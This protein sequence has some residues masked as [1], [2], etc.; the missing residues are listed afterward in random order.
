MRHF[1]TRIGG[2]RRATP[3]GTTLLEALDI[4]PARQTCLATVGVH[5]GEQLLERCGTP[6]GRVELHEITG[7]GVAQ[8]LDWALTLD[9]QRLPGMTAERA[10]LL[11]RAGVDGIALLRNRNPEWVF[12]RC[13]EL[14]PSAEAINLQLVQAW[15]EKALRLP[16]IVEL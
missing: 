9:L 1:G 15:V 10:R 16:L 5:T 6:L 11:R 3:M 13:L 7:L 4:G 2:I 14:D 12:E 8:L